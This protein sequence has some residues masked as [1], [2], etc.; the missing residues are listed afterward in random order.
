MARHFSPVGK[1]LGTAYSRDGTSPAGAGSVQPKPS[2]VPRP[3][4]S[5]YAEYTKY[6]LITRQRMFYEA[7]EDI[8]PGVKII[9]N[10]DDG[11]ATQ[12]TYLGDLDGSF[13]GQTIQN[14]GDGQ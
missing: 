5:E 3:S 14:G 4:N 9:I 11:T 10:N 7:M 12:R 2:P 1:W 8:L 6:P 13:S